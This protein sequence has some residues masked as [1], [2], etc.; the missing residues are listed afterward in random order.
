MSDGIPSHIG[1]AAQGIS[2]DLAAPYVRAGWL[3]RLAR[4]GQH[5]PRLKRLTSVLDVYKILYKV[6]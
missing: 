3:F 6:K 5:V 1:L 2:A 4:T